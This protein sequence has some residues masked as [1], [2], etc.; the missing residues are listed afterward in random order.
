[1][2]TGELSWQQ[3]RTLDSMRNLNENQQMTHYYKYLVELNEWISHQ[4]K[5]D[6]TTQIITCADGMDIVFLVDFTGSMFTAINAIKAAITSIVAAI[7]TES[8]NNYRLGLVLFDEYNPNDTLPQYLNKYLD[9]AAYTSLPAAQRYVNLYDIDGTSSDR[10]QYITAMEMLSQNN[11]SSFTTQLNVIS[12]TDF[13]LGYGVNGPEPA[14]MGIDRIVN[15][16]IAGIFRNDVSKF[17]ILIT[18]NPSSGNDDINNTADVT[19][20]NTLVTDCNA[21]GI[22]VL[23]MKATSDSYA[24]L[25]T[26]ATGTSG[27]V[28]NEYTPAAIISSIQNICV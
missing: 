15:Y 9:K 8:G 5:G 20:A 10:I 11:Q 2:N 4:N 24:P 23:L 6:L 17:I 3:F 27:L 16:D 14:D 12:T 25:E 13:P 22:K 26:I 18:D 28:S 19:F 1:M 21:K 7:V